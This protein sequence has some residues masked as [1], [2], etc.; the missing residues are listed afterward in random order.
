MTQILLPTLAL[1]VIALLF[2]TVMGRWSGCWSRASRR[3]AEGRPGRP[4]GRGLRGLLAGSF[5]FAGGSRGLVMYDGEY[6]RPSS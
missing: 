1:M 2:D 5:T 6:S 3:R 4:G